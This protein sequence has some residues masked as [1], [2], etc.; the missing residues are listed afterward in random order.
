MSFDLFSYLDR[1]AQEGVT[2]QPIRGENGGF[3]LSGSS[4]VELDEQNPDLLAPPSTD[5]GSVDNAKWPFSLSHNRLEKGGWAREQNVKV[6]PSYVASASL[7][8]RPPS[9]YSL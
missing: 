5:V 2:P 1:F 4:N 6:L 8:Y 7:P 3:V 9:D